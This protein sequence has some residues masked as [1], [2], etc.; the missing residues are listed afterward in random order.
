[1]ADELKAQDKQ[2]DRLPQKTVKIHDNLNDLNRQ[3]RKI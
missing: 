1:M 2:L 3:V